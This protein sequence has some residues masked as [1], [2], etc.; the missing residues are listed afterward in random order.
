[1]HQ[2]QNHLAMDGGARDVIYGDAITKP[3]CNGWRGL[4]TY[5]L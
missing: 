5:I 2:T 4:I 3:T 1:M